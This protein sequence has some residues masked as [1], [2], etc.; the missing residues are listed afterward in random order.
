MSFRQ[1]YTVETNLLRSL[2]FLQQLLARFGNFEAIGELLCATTKMR[3]SHIG[4]A[5][6]RPPH[7]GVLRPLT[8]PL[9]CGPK[10]Q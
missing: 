3:V 6:G 4:K 10:Y 7:G 2:R 1:P 8:A 5:H 9:R